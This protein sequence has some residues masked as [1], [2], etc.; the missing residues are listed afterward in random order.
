MRECVE[1][2]ILQAYF[3]G[4]LSSEMTESVAGHLASCLVCTQVARE[5]EAESVLLSEALAPEFAMSVPSERLRHRL[6]AALAGI[7]VVQPVASKSGIGAWFG[8]IAEFFTLSP[9]RAFGYAGLAAG[10]VIVTIIG[11]SQFK[12]TFINNTNNAGIVSMNNAN[13]AV[14]ATSPL[15]TPAASP[16]RR[17]TVAVN[18]EP[19]PPVKKRP[20][21][22]HAG[23]PNQSLLSSQEPKFKLLPGE[24]SYLKTIAALD[25]TIK[26]E[27]DTKPMR[28]S[29][30]V[31]YQR[32]LA[33]VD[34]AIAATRNAAKKNP[35]DPDAAEFMF[36]AYQ[37]KVDLLNQ[38]ADARL[39]NK[40]H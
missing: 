21:N 2:G 33:M 9:Q 17:E 19:A 8:S 14:G 13:N 39:S 18:Q 7:R 30:Q 24:R 12:R 31:E 10:I 35:N 11:V 40:Q 16:E 15:P 27:N 34:R 38:V 29:L 28:P 22:R 26:A 5:L 23:I 4:E 25:T 20:S 32:N 36:A 1:E 37:S 3:D 6:D